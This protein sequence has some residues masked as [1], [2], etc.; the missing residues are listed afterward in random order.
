MIKQLLLLCLLSIGIV[1]ATPP[2]SEHKA[3]SEFSQIKRSEYRWV[4][5]QWKNEMHIKTQSRSSG[6]RS[7][8]GS[9]PFD[10]RRND[11]IGG[12][13]PYPPKY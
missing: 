3:L 5:A 6:R 1:A 10:P 11:P 7:S 2:M 4:L 9:S 12:K 13:D 8:R